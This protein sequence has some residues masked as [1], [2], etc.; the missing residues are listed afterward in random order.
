MR[1]RISRAGSN[2]VVGRQQRRPIV[3]RIFESQVQERRT[4]AD[5]LL[6]VTASRR[7]ST[8]GAANGELVV[9]VDEGDNYRTGRCTELSGEGRRRS[10]DVVEQPAKP[11]VDLLNDFDF[12]YPGQL[13]IAGK[14]RSVRAP[15]WYPTGSR[16][17]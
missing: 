17:W 4:V 7:I 5:V 11:E 15:G 9:I 8:R 6:A 13:L 3:V 16:V 10:E 2:E 12:E 14:L 1:L